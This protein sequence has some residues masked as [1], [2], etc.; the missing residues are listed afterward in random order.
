[1]QGQN[2]YFLMFS[3]V[4]RDFS[5]ATIRL[6]MMKILR[7]G[8]RGPRMQWRGYYPYIVYILKLTLRASRPMMERC[9]CIGIFLF[10]QF[11][12]QPASRR[13]CFIVCL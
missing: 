12:G 4:C 11:W 9:I 10:T 6:K 7:M 8:L 2:G 3:V 13:A 1:V 5:A